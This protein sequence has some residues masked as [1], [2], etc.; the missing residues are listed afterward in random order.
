MIKLY[1]K[2][3]HTNAGTN[4]DKRIC[5]EYLSYGDLYKVKDVDMGQY[6]TDIYLENYKPIFNSVMFDFYELTDDNELK[7]FDIYSSAEFNP[8]IKATE[9]KFDEKKL[10]QCIDGYLENKYKGGVL[11]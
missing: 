3:V 10:K 6:C 1:A 4:S 8:F 5:T 7:P 11:K 9:L 2:Y